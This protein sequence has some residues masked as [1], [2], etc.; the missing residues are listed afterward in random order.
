MADIIIYVMR[1]RVTQI[2]LKRA[3]GGAG[4][5][6]VTCDWPFLKSLICEKA[7]L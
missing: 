4:P 1:W 5:F 6:S 2:N 7:K 3:G